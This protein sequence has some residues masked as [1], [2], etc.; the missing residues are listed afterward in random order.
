VTAA[1]YDDLILLAFTPEGLQ[2]QIYAL[3]SF[4]DLRQL[5][6]NLGKTKVLIF[7]ASKS[8]LT[9]LHLNYQGAEL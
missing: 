7:N 9:D 4:C 2:R 6:V 5:T 1:F 3:A 8:S